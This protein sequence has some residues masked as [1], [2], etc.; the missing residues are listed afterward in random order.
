MIEGDEIIRSD[1]DTARVLNTFFS[2]IVSNLKIPEYTKCD[3][4]SEFISDPVFKAAVKYR[5]HSSI[6]K[7][8]EVRHSS[9]PINFSFSTVKRK[10]IWTEIT[11]LISSIVVQST[12]IPTKSFLANFIF[13]FSLKNAEIA[14]GIK[15]CD[16]NLKLI[17]DQLVYYQIYQ[18]FFNDICLN[19]FQ[20]LCSQCSQNINAGLERDIALDTLSLDALSTDLSMVFYR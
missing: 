11:R 2:Y 3:P 16:R 14:L 4:L 17:S 19:K 10:Q 18:I 15:K 7:T 8:W 1:S 6:L 12:D 13:S 5:N 9:K 20:N